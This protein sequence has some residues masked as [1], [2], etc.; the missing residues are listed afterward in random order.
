MNHVTGKLAAWLG[1]ELD[2]AT[3]ASVAAHLERCP[4]CRR[5]AEA[6][7]AAWRALESV[8]TAPSPRGSV[9]PAVRRRTFG[10]GAGNWFFGRSPV[11]RWSLAALTVAAGVLGGRLTGGLAGAGAA[12][13]DDDG[14]LAAVWLE[15]SSWHDE[16]GGGLADSWLAL[17]ANETSGD[18]A[19]QG[20][21]R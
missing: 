13:A 21:S 14:S 7:R 12:L 3:A 18:G 6:Q 9:W 20:G 10:A 1:G 2:A 8:A 19:G 15:D 17:A 16:S 4:E 11:V 5:E